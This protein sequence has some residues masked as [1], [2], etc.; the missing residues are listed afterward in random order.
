M[1]NSE[2]FARSVLKVAIAQLCQHLE[3]D[4]SEKEAFEALTDITGKFIETIGAQAAI[5]AEHDHRTTCNFVDFLQV[6]DSMDP[7][8]DWRILKQMCTDLHWD[9]PF[10]SGVPDF[11]I[12]GKVESQPKFGQA[13]PGS[14]P[15]DKPKK[16]QGT[17]DTGAAGKPGSKRKSDEMETENTDAESAKKKSKRKKKK[18]ASEDKEMREKD[19]ASRANVPDFF[20]KFPEPHSFRHTVLVS[21][22]EEMNTKELR[23][24][25]L[26]QR[27]LVQGALAKV[28]KADTVGRASQVVKFGEKKEHII[29]SSLSASATKGNKPPRPDVFLTAKKQQPVANRFCMPP[30]EP[31]P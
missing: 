20:P 6:F 9:V 5:L 8:I 16:P 24:K 3:F 22:K 13:V 28:H 2:E 31:S 21:E 1:A 17:A 7:R 23:K 30:R 4:L 14:E 27:R 12:G 11:P 26:Q 15:A 29:K 25:S 19:A 10:T 18:K